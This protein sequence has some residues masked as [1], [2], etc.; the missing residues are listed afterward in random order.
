MGNTANYFGLRPVKHINGSSWNGLTEK[1]WVGSD[2]GVALYIGDPVMINNDASACDAA[3]LYTG[4]ELSIPV[5]PTAAPI[6]GVV[7][8][9]DSSADISDKYVKK[10]AS[11]DSFLNVCVD[12]T[13]IYHIRDNGGGTPSNAWPFLNA[14]LIAATA[15]SDLTGLSGVALNGT[16]APAITQTLPVTIIRLANLPD[17]EMA[18]YAIWEVLINTHQ[19]LNGGV[20]GNVLGVT[21]G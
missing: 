11:V 15:G 13:V 6:Y 17:N 2:Y 18:D 1:C 16:Q 5:T 14:W 7:T 21:K 10:P 12:P 8:S 3:A 9:I 20:A 4:V 19:L